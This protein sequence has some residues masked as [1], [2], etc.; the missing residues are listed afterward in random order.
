MT[1]EDRVR[2]ATRAIA[3]AVHDVPPLVLPDTQ[4]VA[5]PP[6]RWRWM[7]PAIAAAAVIVI[8]VALV[9]VRDAR[10]TQPSVPPSPVTFSGVPKYY[11][12]IHAMPHQRQIVVGNTFTGTRVAT[13]SPPAHSGFVAVT[14]AADDR[15]FVVGTKS[16]PFPATRPDAE[17]RTWY[18][19]RIAPGTDHPATLIRLPIPATPS[20]LMVVGLALS[21]DG[22]KFAVAVQPN[23]TYN[24]GPETLRIY[25]VATGALLGTWTGRTSNIIYDIPLSMNTDDNIY[26]TWLADGHTIAFDYGGGP[27]HPGAVRM[28]DTSRPGHDLIADSR[29]IAGSSTFRNC[30]EPLVT[31]D[32]KT[33]A[34]YAADSGFSEYSTAT[35]QLTRTLYQPRS[36]HSG[37][38]V[39]ASSSGDTLIGYMTSSVLGVGTTGATVGVVT[40]GKFSRLSFPIGGVPLPNGIAW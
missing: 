26:L 20:G 8:A 14:G 30:G 32:G 25:S 15:T 35:G 21:P 37:T 33:L 9:T 4:R 31:S 17:P 1:V 13:I 10:N 11:V 29:P 22:S 18:L 24:F 5:R 23:T 36:R 6:R 19:L 40:Q 12:A 3:G 38:V 16:F 34:C 27:G 7:A 28:L 39:W 2:A